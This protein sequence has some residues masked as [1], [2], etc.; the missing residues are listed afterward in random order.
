MG[1]GIRVITSML[2]LALV[3]CK[4]A[5]QK[6]KLQREV[7]T[8]QDATRVEQEV[9]FMSSHTNAIVDWP[10]Q[11]TGL[12]FTIDVEPIFVRADH[13]PTL[14]Y[15]ILEDIRRKDDKTFLYFTTAPSEHEPSLRLIL[16][17]GG[18]DLV[19][20]KSSAM[21]IGEFA[22]VAQVTVADKSIDATDDGPD[23]ILQG[24]FIDARYV[25]DYAVDKL[26]DSRIGRTT[27][28]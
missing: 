27:D 21:K 20:F 17:C 24:K 11:I 2:I 8:H 1:Y 22:I 16:D 5:E 3:G 12:T 23:Y 9:A 6:A 28:E 15:A 18:C 4:S 19:T 26:L 13:R 10:K 25:G 7:Q 14:F